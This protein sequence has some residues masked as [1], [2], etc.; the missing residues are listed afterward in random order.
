MAKQLL[1]KEVTAALN[2]RM[3]AKVA[4][5]KT[6]GVE[7]TLCIIRLGERPDDLT[8]EKGA[9]K[10]AEEVGVAIKNYIL[11][12][13]TTKEELLAVID[14]INADDSVH[15]VLMFRP[16]P[17]HLRDDEVE[18][19][20]R[21]DPRKDVDGI[22]DLSSAGMYM[23]KPLGFPPCTPSAVVEILDHYG[24]D[25][26][27]KDI[28][29]IGM[30]R[31]VG[32]PAAVLLMNRNATVNVCHILSHDVQEKAARAEIIVSA[33]GKLGLVGAG[34]VSP[35]QIV[36][37]VGMNWDP[38]KNGMSG[39]VAYADVE[40]IVDMI[41]PVPGGVGTVTSCILISHVVTAAER[42]LQ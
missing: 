36:I 40:P 26:T 16:L 31:V 7:P 8:Y 12:E 13:E 4:E 14:G 23:N 34:H 22:T 25:V 37:D 6:K 24:I 10:R 18:I 1:G 28:C 21:L 29:I 42:T 11:P 15:G 33:A 39:D 41:T 30:S 9:T 17:V 32:M 20:N 3:T 38:A 5:L 2:E 19:C 27:G 35:G